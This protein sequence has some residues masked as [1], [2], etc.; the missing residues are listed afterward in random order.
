MI[1]LNFLHRLFTANILYE[2]NSRNYRRLILLNVLLYVTIVL[3]ILF[4]FIN[5]FNV[6]D[7]AVAGMD[8]LVFFSL[9]YASYDIHQYKRTQRAVYIFVG[10]LFIFLL[11][12]SLVNQNEHYGL[13]WT[14]FFPIVTLLL[15]NRKQ[16]FVIVNLFYLILLPLAYMGIGVW[17]NGEWDII[18]FLRFMAASVTLTYIAYF[19][20]Y[21]QE[22]SEDQLMITRQKEAETMKSL[23]ELSIKDSLTKLY[24][25]R[26]L[27]EVFDREFSTAK[28]HHYYFGFFILD[29]DF[30]KQYNDTYGHQKGD[31]ALC[32][33]A[34]ALQKYMRRSEDY[35]FRLGGEEFCG[36]CVSDDE[37]KIQ[38]QLKVLVHAIESLQVAHKT[39]TIA[40]VMTV[41]MGVKIINNYDEYSFDMLYKE[42]DEALYKAKEQGRN[43]IIFAQ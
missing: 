38:A 1:E 22:L 31:E 35:V 41:S 24:N 2:K 33:L 29:I 39:S 17:Q 5:I 37:S 15:M 34:D 19:M 11:S 14:I 23:H 36:I 42:A 7:Y 10:I 18:S 43:R 40:R 21:S 3:S 4:A 8:V 13:I 20:E 25:R 30:F 9:S 6:Q 27:N 28:R 12:F 32:I 16:G 26:Y